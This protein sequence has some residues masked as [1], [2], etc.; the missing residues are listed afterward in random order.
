MVYI[1]APILAPFLA[2]AATIGLTLAIEYPVIYCTGI[3]KNGSYIVAVNALTNVILNA[4]AIIVYAFSLIRFRGLYGA[5]VYSWIFL[6]EISIIP[7]SEALLYTKVSEASQK[8]VMIVTYIANILSFLIG[9][10]IVGLL[11]GKGIHGIS[12]FFIS[13]RGGI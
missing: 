9:L 3:T 1:L 2:L 5:G 13:L 12:D 11:T 6:L 7:I 4:G 10:I 8:K